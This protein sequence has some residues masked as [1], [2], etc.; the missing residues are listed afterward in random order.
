MKFATRTDNPY[1]GYLIF[2][3]KG[4]VY[5]KIKLTHGGGEALRGG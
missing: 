1:Y 5:S 2:T 4:T 3:C